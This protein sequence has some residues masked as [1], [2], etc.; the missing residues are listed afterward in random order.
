M[1]Y[2]EFI[3][4]IIATRGQ[5][6]IDVRYSDRGYA[7]HHIIPKCLGGEPLKLDWSE[8]ENVIWLYPS[9]HFIAHKLL[10]LENS[11]NE[12]LVCAYKRM[13]YSNN[14]K[15]YI[16]SPDDF[17]LVHNLFVKTHSEHLRGKKQKSHIIHNKIEY[18]KQK[19]E[20]CKGVNNPMYGKGY[21]L[22]GGNNGHATIRYFF[23]ELTFECRNDLVDYLRGFDKKISRSTIAG[24]VNGSERV[25]REHKILEGLTWEYKNENQVN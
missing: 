17:E 21:K 18:S 6:S 16:V 8:H 22:A 23:G 14:I 2:K 5:W 24:F 15:K 9:E 10:A 7:R 11:D 3:D 20:Q 1:L 4:N 25:R 19:S 12:G 13:C